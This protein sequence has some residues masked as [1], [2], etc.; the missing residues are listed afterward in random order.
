M[1]ELPQAWLPNVRN[2]TTNAAEM[3]KEI[4]KVLYEGGSSKLQQALHL[5]QML[6]HEREEDNEEVLETTEM[7]YDADIPKPVEAVHTTSEPIKTPSP[8]IS[9][10][11]ESSAPKAVSANTEVELPVIPAGDDHGNLSRPSTSRESH[12]PL[13]EAGTNDQHTD[14][15]REP[16]RMPSRS[17]SIVFLYSSADSKF[18]EPKTSAKRGLADHESHGQESKRLKQ[19]EAQQE[20]IE[21]KQAEEGTKGSFSSQTSDVAAKVP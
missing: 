14:A 3:P 2:K 9:L 12:S 15:G 16:E 1:H 6:D 8:N 4:E 10:A 5:G 20:V 21:F 17:P 19:E 13:L 11:A 18:P 7:A